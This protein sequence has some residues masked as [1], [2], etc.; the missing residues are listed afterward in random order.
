MV[1]LRDITEHKKLEAE[2]Q[3]YNEVLEEKVSERTREIEQ[4]KTV[5]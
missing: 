2:L 4:A 5:H 1:Q 3:R